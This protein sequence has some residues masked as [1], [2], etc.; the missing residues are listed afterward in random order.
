MNLEGKRTALSKPR[1]IVKWPEANS[2]RLEILPTRFVLKTIG[3]ETSSSKL[4]A[5]LLYNKSIE[6]GISNPGNV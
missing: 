2:K 5:T 6:K 3:R 4:V 1:V